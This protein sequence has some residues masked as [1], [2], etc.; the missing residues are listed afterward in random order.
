MTDFKPGDIVDITIKGARIAQAE[1]RNGKTVLI[2]EPYGEQGTS[3]TFALSNE[4]FSVTPRATPAE[5]P[6][7][8]GDVWRTFPLTDEGDLVAVT[9]L[10]T[11]DMWNDVKAPKASKFFAAESGLE[12]AIADVLVESSE[13]PK[14]LYREMRDASAVSA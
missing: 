10:A 8:A 4:R 11:A 6:P 9:W 14:L 5:W 12:R 1:A 13:A 3:F 2:V 7:Q